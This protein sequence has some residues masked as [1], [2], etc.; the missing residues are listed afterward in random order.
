MV[1]EVKGSGVHATAAKL[2]ESLRSYL[3]AQYHIRDETLIRERRLLLEEAGA[4]AQRPFVES[5]PVYELGRPYAELGLPSVVSD[6]LTKVSKLGVGLYPTPYVHQSS[7]LARFFG[8]DARDLIVATGTGSGKTE[9]FLMPVIGQLALEAEQRPQTASMDGFRA[10]LLYPMN[11]L[12]NDQLSRIRRLFGTPSASAIISTGRGRPVR[13]GSYTGRSPYPGPRTDSRDTARIEPLFEDF[14]LPLLKS[15][16]LAQLQDIGQWPAKD[17]AAFYAEH[18]VERKTTSSGKT[19]VHRHWKERLQT[20]PQDRELM[21]RDEAQQHCPDLLITNY[22]MLEYMLMRPIER[23]I[24][25]QTRD[26]L[27]SDERNELTI[28]LDEAHMYRGAGGAE[29]ALLIRRLIARLDAPRERVRFILTSA[30]LGDG[31]EAQQEITEFASSLTGL[32]PTSPRRF[33]VITGTRE[34]RSATRDAGTAEVDAFADFSIADF[35]KNATEPRL[36]GDAVTHLAKRVGWK[37]PNDR[38][39]QDY[40]FEH[41]TGFGPLERLVEHVSG[42]ATALEDLAAL[43]FPGHARSS[44]AL[45]SMLALATFARRQRDQRVLLPTRLHMFFRGLPGLFACVDEK[46]VSARYVSD[47]RLLGRLHTH[48]RSECD[49]GSRV[50]E[51]LTHRECGAAYLRAYVDTPRPDFL[52]AHPSGP[53]REGRQTPLF[54]LDMLI[55]PPS[56]ALSDLY[57]EAW[58]DKRSGRLVYVQPA[59]IDGFRKVFIPAPSHDFAKHGLR[60]E[61]CPVCQGKAARGETSTIMDHATKGEAPFANLVKTQLDNQPAVRS[62]DREFPNGGRKV[63]LFSDGRQK[64]ARLARDIPREVEQDLFRQILSIATARLEKLGIEPR[65]NRQLYIAILSV[66]RDA[67]LTI[68]DRDDAQKVEEELEKLRKDHAADTLSELLSDFEPHDQPSRYHI[69]ML[70]QLCGRYYSIVGATVGYLGPAKKPLQN[71]ITLFASSHPTLT[72]DDVRGISGAWIAEL[73]DD[74]AVDRGLE[75]NV[76]GR[77]AGYF[78]SSWGSNGTF[79]KAVK[80]NFARALGLDLPEFQAL[81]ATLA[82]E[83]GLKDTAGGLFLDPTKLTVKIDLAMPWYQCQRCTALLPIHIRGHCASCAAPGVEQLDPNSNEYI[84]ARKGFWREP[85]IA[86]RAAETKLRGISV[87]EHTA[88]LSNRD[89]SR[90]HSTTEQFELRFKD[91]KVKARDRPIDVLSCTTTMEVGVDIGSLVAV[92]LRNVPPQRENYQQRAGRAGRRGASVSTVITYAQNGPHDSYFYNS[93]EKIVAGAPRGPEIKVDNPKIARRHVTSFLFQTFFHSYMD[94]HQV[95]IGG[96]TSALFRALGTA[97]DFFFGTGEPG[98]D[99]AEFTAWINAEVLEPTGE[100]RSQ[101]ASW[102]PENLRTGELSIEEWIET[103]AR[104]LLNDLAAVT[105]DADAVPADSSAVEVPDT[106]EDEQIER[107]AI[108]DEELLEFLF[109]Q[110]M[111]PSYAFPTDLTSFLVEKL[112]KRDPDWKMEIIERP[113]QAVGKALSEYAPGRLIVINK[114]TYRSGGVAANTLPTEPNRAELLFVEPR[115]LVHCENCSF[116]RDLDDGQTSPPSCPIC[117]NPVATTPMLTPQVFLPEDGKP[118]REDDRDQEI[119]YATSA[120]F[121]VPIGG[122]DLP[123]LTV[124]GPHLSFVVTTDRRLVTTNKGQLSSDGHVGFWVCDKCG[125]ASTDEQPAGPHERPYK[126]EF[127]FGIPRAPQRCSGTF[128]NVFLGHVFSTDLLLLRIDLAAPLIT[129]TGDAL[130]LRTLED[131][132]FTIA[133]G[134]RL[135]ASR[136]P[137][138]DLDPSEFGAGFRIVPGLQPSTLMLDIYLYDTLSGGAGYAELAARHMST[139]L[140]DTLGLLEGCP[141]GCDLSCE[142]CLKHY[143]NQHLKDR[144]DRKL[145]AALLRYAMVGEVPQELNPTDQATSLGA[146]RRSL[147]M[148]GFSCSSMVDVGG[149]MAPLVVEKGRKRALVGTHPPLLAPE[150]RQHSLQAVS[151]ASSLILNQYILSRNLPDE[152]QLV[153]A[154]VLGAH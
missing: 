128:H 54:E 16:A 145:G 39:L 35:E 2:T 90:V 148:D 40:L 154:K 89:N 131:A 64:A 85:V 49:C 115:H 24:F 13:F 105:S 116:V 26:W 117:G 104:Q 72:N 19:R 15:E 33:A 68:F 150:W 60:F 122:D 3:E 95:A 147:E 80:P 79:S 88:Q 107:S 112:V 6:T 91:V 36:A 136:H 37:P 28:V 46:C 83:F 141:A 55:E 30:S 94:T 73:A 123:A 45:A 139:V 47:D 71:L 20:Q 69:A 31:P 12:V 113:Q 76:R 44:E 99:L 59:P 78:K 127:S 93:P 137:Q 65:P 119:T 143:H 106:D 70:K 86:A 14:Y 4:V 66:L 9:S 152:H 82:S 57:S 132:L 102:L 17:M 56:E 11:A 43:V 53:F 129:D 23:P 58:L 67:D 103:V 87:E 96:A 121:P 146:L 125:K 153:R 61:V 10:L 32:A 110:G 42:K 5:T 1:I 84:R 25:Q 7:A 52:W 126:V 51:L 138:L 101:I 114:E 29:V 50:F 140:Q 151:G 34:V 48:A 124:V 18:A 142:S 144:L 98:L 92:G 134:L 62:E 111:L 63:L 149:T 38:P 100:L 41:L 135:S 97:K 74:F 130:Q 21:T 22:S 120:Q 109:A 77:A 8:S 75:G 81:E 27:R 133:E 118:L 108:G